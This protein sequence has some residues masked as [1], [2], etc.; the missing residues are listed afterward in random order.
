MQLSALRTIEVILDV[1]TP[2]INFWKET[3]LDAVGRCWVQLID[4]EQENSI[5]PSGICRFSLLSEFGLVT[6][7]SLF[8]EFGQRLRS[9]LKAQL[10]HIC[11]KLAEVCPSVIQVKDSFLSS[12]CIFIEIL[13]GI[14][15]VHRG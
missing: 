3:I 9:N 13:G 6:L 12:H 1:C 11:A 10:Q 2:R 15:T 5:P 8:T 14:Q 7:S 4:E